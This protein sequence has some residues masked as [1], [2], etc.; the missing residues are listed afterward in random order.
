MFL[1]FNWSKLFKLTATIDGFIVAVSPLI[2][3]AINT[4]AI[5]IVDTLTAASLL[6]DPGLSHVHTLIRLT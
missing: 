4:G 2:M 3:K 6:V 1:T 5:I